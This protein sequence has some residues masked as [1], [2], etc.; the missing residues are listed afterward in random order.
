MNSSILLPQKLKH[1][2]TIQFTGKD[3]LSFLQGQV[4]NDINALDERW[5]FSGYCNPKGRLLALFQFWRVA[6]T[7]YGLLDASLLEETIKR[8]RMYVMRSD[9]TI[10]VLDNAS[11]HGIVDPQLGGERFSLE[12]TENDHRLNYGGQQL[13][14]NL[15]D[16]DLAQPTI[17]SNDI[18][19]DGSGTSAWSAISIA[20]GL[21][22]ITAETRELFVPQMINLDLIGG[23]N[24]KK[25][26]YTGQEIVARMH[27]LGKLKQR[28]YVCDL[29][30][31]AQ[32]QSAI[33]HQVGAG[34]KVLTID[35]S[36]SS[37]NAGTLVAV[38]HDAQLAL[39]VLR[40]E[41]VNARCG[42]SLENGSALSVRHE[43]PYSLTL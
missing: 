39:A 14:V 32:E 35:E 9:V 27:Y 5:Q 26:C 19:E 16:T 15:N 29:T 3:T 33:E 30:N 24:F 31:I 43:Q 37:K 23:V 25:G 12:I 2:A 40:I 11:C 20:R 28:M 10:E 17:N 21:P 34:D 4:S 22:S 7:V 6:D 42:F 8:L 41:M 18:N 38:E 1:L 36:G 13:I